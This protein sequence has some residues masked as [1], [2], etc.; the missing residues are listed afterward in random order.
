MPDTSASDFKRIILRA[1]LNDVSP[2]VARV[3]AVP[4]DLEICELHELFLG[5]LGWTFD[6]GFIIRIH[7]Q[8]FNSFQHR[9]RDKRL[10]DFKLR[11]QEKFLYVCDTLDL[12]E[13]ELRV[14]DIQ[15]GLAGEAGPACVSG[16]GYRLMLDRQETGPGVSDPAM[17]AAS[18]KA[19]AEVYR[20]EPGM[21]W[22]LL[23]EAVNSGWKS[24]EVRLER[25]G[26][27][28]PTRFNLKET[29]ERLVLWA[30]RRRRLWR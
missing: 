18:I 10:R 8:E 3:I 4:D 5:M 25:S 21:D 16:R 19:L 11:R 30:Q 20:D 13:W 15:E 14:L 28:S 9:S 23:E 26:P 22:S 27:L 6:T 1:V 12:W 7:A 29:N 24:V 17:I 2:I